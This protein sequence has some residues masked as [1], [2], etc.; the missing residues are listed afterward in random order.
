M[1]KICPL[2]GKAPS[3]GNNRS[4]SLRATRRRFLPNLQTKRVIDPVTGQKFTVRLSTSAIRSLT[5]PRKK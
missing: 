2:T 3:A 4:H 5:K 1:S